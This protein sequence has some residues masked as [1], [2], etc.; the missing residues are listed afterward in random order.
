[1]TAT[2]FEFLGAPP[3]TGRFTR[4]G[5]FVPARPAPSTAPSLNTIVN[6][7]TDELQ[8]KGLPRDVTRWDK[9]HIAAELVACLP[10]SI[11]R[12]LPEEVERP[13][14]TAHAAYAVLQ[15]AHSHRPERGDTKTG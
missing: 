9:S 14:Y 10:R 8:I 5:G 4:K 2:T 6:R 7:A 13:P 11:R 3:R 1:M 15:M 12:E